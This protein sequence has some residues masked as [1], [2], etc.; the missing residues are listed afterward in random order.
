MIDYLNELREACLEAYTGII[1][2]LRGETS[3]P[4]APS[5]ELVLVQQYVP[6]LV[7][8]IVAVAQDGERSDGCVAACA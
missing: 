4:G 3:S 8:F 6:A 2:G 5:Q 7:Q 1:Q